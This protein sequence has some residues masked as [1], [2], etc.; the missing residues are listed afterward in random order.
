MFS[1]EEYEKEHKEE[2]EQRRKELAN[3]LEQDKFIPKN[4]E[5]RRRVV[6]DKETL[7]IINDIVN[8]IDKKREEL[9]E[10]YKKHHNIKAL[11][12]IDK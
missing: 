3:I 7:N 4:R 2:L 11:K 12:N 10:K 1:R 6:M 5:E 9:K 8:K